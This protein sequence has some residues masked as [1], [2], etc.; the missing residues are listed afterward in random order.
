M[1]SKDLFEAGE[2][3]GVEAAVEEGVGS[4]HF[5]F[6]VYDV[7]HVKF[8]EV[9][10]RTVL[11]FLMADYAGVLLFLL[12]L[13]IVFVLLGHFVKQVFREIGGFSFYTFEFLLFFLFQNQFA[14]LQLLLIYVIEFGCCVY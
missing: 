8:S 3:N 6:A 4:L 13:D 12:V 1:I 14:F 9:A 5:E 7:G 10:Q 2:V 11:A